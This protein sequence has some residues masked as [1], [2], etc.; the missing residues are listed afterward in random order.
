MPAGKSVNDKA[1]AITKSIIADHSNGS[2]VLNAEN[3]AIVKNTIT[4]RVKWH[5]SMNQ[6]EFVTNWCDLLEALICNTDLQCKVTLSLIK[7]ESLLNMQQFD[8]AQ[9][10]AEKLVE[11]SESSRTIEML[12]KTMLHAQRPV[13]IAVNHFIDTIRKGQMRSAKGIAASTELC[14]ENLSRILSC[15]GIAQSSKSLLPMERDRASQLLLK[16]WLNQYA[17]LK[18]WTIETSPSEGLENRMVEETLDTEQSSPTMTYFGVAKDVVQLFLTHNMER[19]SATQS[20]AKNVPPILDRLIKDNDEKVRV[21]TSEFAFVV[22]AEP[23]ID[24]SLKASETNTSLQLNVTSIIDN[25][26]QKG[27]QSVENKLVGEYNNPEIIAVNEK[28]QNVPK[29]SDQHGDFYFIGTD[30]NHD[31]SSLAIH[32][33]KCSLKELK[34]EV[35]TLLHTVISVIKSLKSSSA[36]VDLL[37]DINDLSWLATLGWDLGKVLIDQTI[38]TFDENPTTGHTVTTKDQRYEASANFFE[39]A[40][41]LYANIPLTIDGTSETQRCICLL[42]SAAARLDMETNRTVNHTPVDGTTSNVDNSERFSTP[43]KRK[44]QR[45]S[46]HCFETSCET[47]PI[48]NSNMETALS[49]LHKAVEILREHSDFEDADTRNLRKRLVLIEF[50]CLCKLMDIKRCQRFIK[51]KEAIF[52]SMTPD[53][54]M[55]CADTARFEVGGSQ[56]IYRQMLAYALQVSVRSTERASR[57]VLMSQIHCKLIESSPTRQTALFQVEEFEQWVVSLIGPELNSCGGGTG[58][59]TGIGNIGNDR[60]ASRELFIAPY[61]FILFTADMDLD[62]ECVDRIVSLAYN[63]GVTLVDLDQVILAEKFV[64]KARQQSNYHFL[65]T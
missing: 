24:L 1:Q 29:I 39:A 33:F 54:L 45:S 57:N 55:S 19:K 41:E 7:S 16:E 36:T 47:S 6:W 51:E 9:K 50:A 42:I 22:A 11:I 53:E 44:R 5:R 26:D 30:L 38:G 56:D 23:S 2:R 10:L 43:S 58:T 59:G 48:A 14:K 20:K 13:D 27:S 65:H 61:R 63:Y 18:M 21:H 49:N 8:E 46:D 17:A 15:V 35:L 62:G 60:V 31:E 3:Y 40:E 28:E 4:E 12:F 34:E 64:T 52:L 37:G 25:Q 32:E